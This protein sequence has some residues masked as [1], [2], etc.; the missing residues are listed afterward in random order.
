MADAAVDIRPTGEAVE[1]DPVMTV[2]AEG[3]AVLLLV[4]AEAILLGPRLVQDLA[5]EAWRHQAVAVDHRRGTAQAAAEEKA[6][7]VDPTTVPAQP[8][9]EGAGE[10]LP[11]GTSREDPA[12]VAAAEVDHLAF[13]P[14]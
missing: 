11:A 12:R 6:A 1:V 3:E 13:R 2:P 8:T 10:D 5:V 9:V 7:T 4:G 14:M